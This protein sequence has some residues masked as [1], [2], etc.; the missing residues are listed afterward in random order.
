MPWELGRD[1]AGID[2][3][4]QKPLNLV[5]MR[6]KIELGL[7]YRDARSAHGHSRRA[8]TSSLCAATTIR[9][10][11]GGYMASKAASCNGC[12]E[13]F[14]P[15]N[16]T[17][18]HIIATDEKG[19]DGSSNKFAAT[20]RALQL[21]QGESR[22]GVSAGEAGRLSFSNRQ[23]RFGGRCRIA[24]ARFSGVS[25]MRF[26]G[27][28]GFLPGFMRSSPCSATCAHSCGPRCIAFAPSY[29]LRAG[30]SGLQ[31]RSRNGAGASG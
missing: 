29:P 17:V 16:F 22:A 3:S 18:D 12:G 9:P 20:L 11:S 28:S 14:K 8:R 13:H 25:G 7:F 27:G 21:G 4:H 10:T 30:C 1:W 19:R 23:R 5:K 2:I 24:F 15:Q 6:T 26:A 31:T